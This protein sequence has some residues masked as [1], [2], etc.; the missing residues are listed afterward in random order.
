MTVRSR[1]EV[2]FKDVESIYNILLSAFKKQV[3]NSIDRRSQFY[4]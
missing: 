4:F 2:I 3:K 1:C